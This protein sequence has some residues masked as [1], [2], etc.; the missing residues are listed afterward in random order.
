MKIIIKSKKYGERTIIID[1]EDYD[2]IKNYNWGL[3]YNSYIDGFYITTN[4]RI[5]KSKKTTLTLH[6]EIMDCPKDKVVDHINRN[7][8]DNRKENLRICTIAENSRNAKKNK[9]GL[10]SE[11]R[12]VNYH[13]S[14]R[15][16]RASIRFNKKEIY[17]G[18]YADEKEAA[19]AYNKAAIKYHGEFSNLNTI[20]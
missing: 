8:L 9:N 4:K 15:K 12:G 7:I 11:Y 3:H 17:L 2:S 1:D 14:A 5:N 20:H 10:T 19:I 6:R 16:Y 18:L 13:K